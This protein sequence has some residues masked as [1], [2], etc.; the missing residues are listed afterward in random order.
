[1]INNCF[2]FRWGWILLPTAVY[3]VNVYLKSGMALDDVLISF[4]KQLARR[5][6]GAQAASVI[7]SKTVKELAETME[8]LPSESSFPVPEVS[9]SIS[10]QNPHT[11]HFS[12][13]QNEARL[14]AKVTKIMDSV[15]EYN[16]L[17]QDDRPAVRE[18]STT[19]SH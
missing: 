3:H 19:S 18:E 10:R 2:R 13:R 1:M 8:C 6:S 5:F 15:I 12:R 11:G 7:M 4:V 14:L 17:A 16:G 9:D